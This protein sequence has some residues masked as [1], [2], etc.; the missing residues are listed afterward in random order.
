[1]KRQE[2]SEDPRG[3]LSRRSFLKGA[4]GVAAG[5]VLATELASAEPVAESRAD[6]SGALIEGE[7]EVAFRLNGAEVKVKVEPR[8]T[9][10]SAL[11]NHL[12]PAHV[13][14]K[15]GCESGNCG[16]CTVLLDG[17]PVYSCLTL[18]VHAHGREVRSAEGLGEGGEPSALQR[19]MVKEDATMCGFCTPGFAVSISA[20]LERDPGA[21]EETIRE[22]CAGNVCR[23]GTYP[24]IF[25]AALE[26][27]RE[28]SGGG[29]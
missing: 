27:G 29:K 13:A 20:Q 9:L 4:G 14:V 21:S 1:M 25:S 12:E 24:Q 26:A 23:C 5:S 15:S 3:R 10:S 11:R 6:I 7:V 16:A 2:K 17:E 22:S 18:A 28:M 8:T 19:A